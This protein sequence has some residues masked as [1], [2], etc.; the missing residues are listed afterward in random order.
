VIR[1][2]TVIGLLLLGVGTLSA[3]A[4]RAQGDIQL[5]RP[6]RVYLDDVVPSP[7][8]GTDVALYLRVE[9]LIGEPVDRLAPDDLAIR[10]DE[11]LVDT[12]A[13]RVERLAEAGEGTSAVLVLDTSRTMSG[14]PFEQA[15]AAALGFLDRMGEFDHVALVSFDDDVRVLADFGA[16]RN[17]ARLSLEQLEVQP[18]T[19]SKM[20][21][22]GANR[23]VELLRTRPPGLP[24]RGFVILFSDGRDS[25]S[26][27]GLDEVIDLARGGAGA[28]RTPVF[29]IGY[30]R[31]GG[32]GLENLDRL[33]HGTG[34]ASF[35]AS[36]PDELARFYDEIW[37]RM[38]GSFVVTYP[39]DMDGTRHTVQVTVGSRSESREADYP[40]ISASIW[41]WVVGGGLVVLV[42]VG[43]LFALR[44]RG[45]G[46]LVF[47]EGAQSG[48]QVP[49]RPGRLRIGALEENDL[50]LNVP[51]VSR[52]H[53]QLHVR[54]GRVEIE[55]L[56]SKN[57]TFVNGVALRT[58]SV[59]SPGDRLRVGDV[60]LV[61]R[62]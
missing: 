37:K 46:R 23:A 54:G 4:V 18:K 50:V 47:E 9:T 40:E 41:P 2:F 11:S 30:S 38:T 39:G 15:K 19:L 42:G 56:G 16:P 52:F 62:K 32:A 20:V 13:I 57:G 60:E 14:E 45:A 53:A 3:D 55:D 5:R 21:W 27:H 26:V 24:S 35:Q 59:L 22:D 29:T 34:A 1:L 61:Y 10:D 51:T 49:L 48:R 17:E 28:G 6:G 8:G 43:A 25:S 33:A 44:L 12:S 31:F 7:A 36:S 58:R